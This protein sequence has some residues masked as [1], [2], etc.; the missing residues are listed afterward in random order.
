MRSSLCLDRRVHRPWTDLSSLRFFLLSFQQATSKNDQAQQNGSFKVFCAR[1]HLGSKTSPFRSSFLGSCRLMCICVAS[2]IAYCCRSARRQ[3]PTDA[4]T[5]AWWCR[6][7]SVFDQ[8]RCLSDLEGAAPPG[9][10]Y[11]RDW[12]LYLQRDPSQRF[13]SKPKLV[14]LCKKRRFYSLF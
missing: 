13:L 2:L 3:T 14:I 8:R 1:V 12:L 11:L 10:L 4:V 9:Q 7:A 5:T 6:P